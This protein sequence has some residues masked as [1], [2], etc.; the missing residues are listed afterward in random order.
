[1]DPKRLS[2]HSYFI[3]EIT[4]SAVCFLYLHTVFKVLPAGPV[5]ILTCVVVT[6]QDLI[7]HPYIY[8][9]QCFLGSSFAFSG[10]G[11]CG[12]SEFTCF[13]YFVGFFPT[14]K[15]RLAPSRLV[16]SMTLFCCYFCGRELFICHFLAITTE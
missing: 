15:E 1:M 12:T 2:L 16:W 4:V 14:S 6:L 3:M 8:K 10:F 9:Y 5:L 11:N 7:E 13:V